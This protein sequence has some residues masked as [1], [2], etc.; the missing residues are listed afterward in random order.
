MGFLSEITERVRRNLERSPLDEAALLARAS[1]MPPAR[2]FAAALRSERPAVIAEVKRASPSAGAIAP[3]DV[4]P[5]SMVRAY[6][7]GG[8][9]SISVLT[10]P[11]HFHGSLSDLRAVRLA[12]RLPV[13]RKDFLIH[14]AQVIESRAAGADA[15]LLIAATLS[16]HELQAML[17]TAGDL[18]L[19]ALVE[20]HTREDLEKALQAGTL[21]VGVNA[22]D[23]E[24]L[25]VDEERAL[26]LVRQVPPGRTVVFESGISSIGQ[27][28]RAVEAGA[29]AV[30]VGEAL[31]RSP[32]PA[33]KVRELRGAAIPASR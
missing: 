33:A 2:D 20:A 22:R 7:A 9:A 26:D 24:S 4:D 27:V 17:A 32:D 3:A 29:Q 8:A 6:E 12:C 23:L 15:V 19:A 18:G 11:H 14:P 13:L 21:I 25:E 5:A 30:L 10:E 31:V 1:A 28:Q 16:N